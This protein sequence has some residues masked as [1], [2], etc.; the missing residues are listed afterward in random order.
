MK[1]YTIK[2][3]DGYYGNVHSLIN[4]SYWSRSKSRLNLVTDAGEAKHYEKRSQAKSYLT[5][6]TKRVEKNLEDAKERSAKNPTYSWTTRELDM[7]KEI[8]ELLSV[9]EIVE[10]DFEEPNF[11][12]ATRK[13]IKWDKWT[14]EYGGYNND[15]TTQSNKICKCCGLKMKNI[16]HIIFRNGNSFRICAFCQEQIGENGKNQLS[17]M[18]QKLKKQVETENFLR[19]I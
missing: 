11:P 5:T 19:S 18:D 15:I 9:A 12:K 3:N 14:S 6:V 17:R 2:V 8:S 16:P 13:S 4:T 7:Y 1:C 10:L